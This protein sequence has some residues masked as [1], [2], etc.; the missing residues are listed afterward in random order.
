MHIRKAIAAALIAGTA[1]IGSAG[2]AIARTYVDIEIAPPASRV[3]PV[4]PPRAGYVWV[5]GVWAWEHRHHVWHKG[6]WIHERQG[7]TYVGPRWQHE[8]TRWRYEEGRWERHHG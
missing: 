6:R 3:E 2:V 5:P 8:G 7:Y 4:P 1:A